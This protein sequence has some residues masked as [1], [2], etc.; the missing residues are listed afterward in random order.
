MRLVVSGN[1]DKAILVGEAD[2]QAAAIAV[3]ESEHADVVLLDVQMP[4]SDGLATIAALRARFPVLGIL[5]CSFDLDPTT[6]Q[7]AIAEG[8]NACMPKP[9]NRTDVHKALAGLPR[10]AAPLPAASAAF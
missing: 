4:I 2:S 7:R 9:V 10:R 6:V 5:A 8:A 3:V 1:D